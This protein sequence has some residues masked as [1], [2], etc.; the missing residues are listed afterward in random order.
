[1][2][3][4]EAIRPI[5][6]LAVA[7]DDAEVTTL[8]GSQTRFIDAR[9]STVWRYENSTWTNSPYDGTEDFL[10]PQT[11]CFS[12]TSGKLYYFNAAL[13]LVSV[14]LTTNTTAP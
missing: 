14:N 1:V 11:L 5:T 10:R 13:E 7:E 4:L 12:P 3:L 9:D 8:K 6:P 2:V